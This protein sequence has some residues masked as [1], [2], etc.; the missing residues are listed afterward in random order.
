MMIRQY[1][2][3]IKAGRTSS[4]LWRASLP[5]AA[6]GALLSL[7]ILHGI[8]AQRDVPVPPDIDSLRDLGFIQALLDGNYWGDPSYAGEWRYC[9]PLV[10]VIIAAM[11]RVSGAD[12]LVLLWTRSGIWLNLLTPLTFFLMCRRLFACSGTAVA[13]T[14]F[15]VLWSGSWY[16]PWLMGGY[17]PWSLTPSIAQ[18]L[19]FISIPAIVTAPP[20]SLRMPSLLRAGLI[21][22]L[23]GLTLLA[24]L[25]PAVILTVVVVAVTIVQARCHPRIIVWLG[26]VA[27]I[28][29]ATA[30]PYLVPTV[31]YYPA[32][33][34]NDAY[35]AYVEPLLRGANLKQAVLVNA[36][37]IL[38]FLATLVLARRRRDINAAGATALITWVSVC[39]AFIIHRYVCALP[40]VGQAHVCNIFVLTVHH[41]HL[42]LQNAWACLMG[43]AIWAAVQMAAQLGRLR[44]YRPATAIVVLA[45][46][47]LGVRSFFNRSYD[48]DARRGAMTDGQVFD[49]QAYR[50]VL[51]STRPTDVFITDLPSDWDCPAAFAVIAAARQVVAAPFDFSNSFVDWTPRN[52]RRQSYL[53]AAARDGTGDG[54]FC[55]LQGQRAY[56]LVPRDFR[57]RSPRLHP[58]Y[59]S[60]YLAA[61]RI[62]TE[63][64]S[65]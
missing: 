37:G 35:S 51:A 33:M 62:S 46:L 27:L 65:P 56:L 43:Y 24:H 18:T 60:A 41:Y 44:G 16:T 8:S 39:S 47:A 58:V 9:P 7:C 2:G 59:D 1:S 25:V 34:L 5:W 55:D 42:Y 15:Y 4:I 3:R 6:V 17:T 14:C 36:P 31:L 12:N 50:W 22:L 57:I 13:A 10:H 26:V 29:L 40:G 52:T 23:I 64:C 30:A 19:F 45:F 11:A 32:G 53:D 21:G 28:E 49:A 61:Y 20:P 38:A 48:A 63:D 54:R